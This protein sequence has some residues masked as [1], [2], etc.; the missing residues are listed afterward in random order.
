MSAGA[1]RTGK[2][3]TSGPG[4][5]VERAVCWSDAEW[6]RRAGQRCWAAEW[7]QGEEGVAAE[8]RLGRRANAHAVT[9]RAGE[10][11]RG[12]GPLRA[13]RAERG[14]G[15]CWCGLPFLFPFSYFKHYSNIIEFKYKFEFN[16]ST[17]T[18]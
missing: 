5:S 18:K 11:R 1:R 4:S 2:D 15:L 17:Q 14:A 8:Q 6:E 16:P 12:A 9:G 13:R 3:L 10:G 7:A